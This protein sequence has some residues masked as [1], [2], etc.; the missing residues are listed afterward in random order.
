MAIW[1][2]TGISRTR[3]DLLPLEQLQVTSGSVPRVEL[4][5]GFVKG[6]VS[7]IMPAYN[8][9]DLICESICE[10]KR[11]FNDVCDD[12]EII[13]VDDGS[14]DSTRKVFYESLQG[15]KVRL[16]SYHRNEGKGY[17]FRKGF[18]RA[19]G[20]FT[21]LIDSDSEIMP[22]VLS[23]YLE[24]LKTADIAIGSKRHPLS[25]VRTPV[26]RR[27]LSLGFNMIERLLTGVKASD[28][29]AGFKGMK[30][31][32]AYRVLPLITSKKFAFDLE[33]LAVAS[34][35]GFKLRE[36]PVSLDLKALISVR[37]VARIM[38]DVAG[39]AYRLRITRWY[40]KNIVTMTNTYRPI[41]DW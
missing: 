20:E 29:Q 41:I 34:L 16:V 18:S 2:C 26:L 8:E 5:D 31:Q 36:L 12:Y 17:A 3:E 4:I 6:R 38:I 27:F 28:T 9:A 22:K 37:R 33:F 32:V 30:S 40:Q 1:R 7:I 35:L 24:A 13:V 19:T 23:A 21:F 11:R 10:V 25:T 14:T 15:D 39:I